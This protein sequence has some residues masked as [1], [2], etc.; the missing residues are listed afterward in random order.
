MLRHLLTLIAS[1]SLVLCITCATL[2]IRSHYLIDV[3]RFAPGPFPATRPS[4]ELLPFRPQLTITSARG[5]LQFLTRDAIPDPNA[6]LGHITEPRRPS[7]I[8]DLNRQHPGDRHWVFAGVHYFQRDAQTLN[9]PN[10]RAQLWGF[11]Y[12][13]LPW[14]H[15]TTLTAIFPAAWF[16]VLRR[17]ILHRRRV[18][19]GLCPGCGYDCRAT[20]DRCPEC[21]SPLRAQ[22]A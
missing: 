7:P 11:H 9:S 22:P 16:L 1:L 14:W 17:R 2:W 21:G 4:S 3:Y 19:Q 15:P 6:P 13:T 18:R 8:Y 10:V 12:L 5:Q 20:P